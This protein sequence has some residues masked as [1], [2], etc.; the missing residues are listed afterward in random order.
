M[1]AL[2]VVLWQVSRIYHPQTPRRIKRTGPNRQSDQLR[3][4][5]RKS[6]DDAD[7]IVLLNGIFGSDEP[8]RK[9][10]QK[11]ELSEEAL[12]DIWGGKWS[13]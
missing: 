6:Q 4:L 2:A 1:A 7:D 5:A 12:D 11:P 13:N 8:K 3:E 9:R 10:T